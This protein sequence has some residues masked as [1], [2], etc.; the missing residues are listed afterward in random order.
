MAANRRPTARTVRS[1]RRLAAALA[2]ALLAGA[3]GCATSRWVDERTPGDLWGTSGRDLGVVRLLGGA[4]AGRDAE[5]RGAPREDDEAALDLLLE[6][7]L[8][9][10]STL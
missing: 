6:L 8:Q 5:R 4:P 3:G 7:V 1:G 2:L 10:L 9:G